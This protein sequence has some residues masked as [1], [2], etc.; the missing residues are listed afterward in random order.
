M[1]IILLAYP[2]AP[3]YPCGLH[4][5]FLVS[6]SASVASVAF[7]LLWILALG[8]IVYSLISSCL[9][10]RDSESAP[11]VDDPH[12]AG[13]GGGSH[14]R[15]GDDDDDSPAPPPYTPG[16]LNSNDKRQPTSSTS[17]VVPSGFFAGLGLG[18]LA[19]W[20]AS[21]QTR[22]RPEADRSPTSFNTFPRYGGTPINDDQYT[23][24]RWGASGMGGDGIAGSS[25]RTR[26]GFGDNQ[27]SGSG[28]GEVRT[29][30]GFGSTSTR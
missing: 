5:T 19:A 26:G 20:L 13:G 18:G 2:S 14:G 24:S 21:R 16:S 12:D 25:R 28:L 9:R 22:S 4:L 30:T 7:T 17:S 6:L 27:G 11:F 1:P 10:P 23:R 29:S 8:F 3:S 15:P